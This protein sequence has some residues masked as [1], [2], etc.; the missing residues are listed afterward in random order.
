MRSLV[1]LGD[2]PGLTGTK[3]RGAL[4]SR[5]IGYESQGEHGMGSQTSVETGPKDEALEGRE[6]KRREERGRYT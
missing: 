6:E 5:D 2:R 4:I 3:S 1:E